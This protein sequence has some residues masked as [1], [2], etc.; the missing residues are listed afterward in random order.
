MTLVNFDGKGYGGP[1]YINGVAS[2]TSQFMFDTANS[3][4]STTSTKCSDCDT[5]YFYPFLVPSDTTTV[6]QPPYSFTGFELAQDVSFSKEDG[7][8]ALSEF[9]VFVMTS[10]TGLADGLDGILGL[11]PPAATDTNTSVL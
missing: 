10:Q 9:N 1:V 8:K 2:E 11:A 7:A 5:S 3:M 4:L 6:S